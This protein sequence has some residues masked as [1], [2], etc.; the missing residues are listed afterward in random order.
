MFSDS[1]FV[2]IFISPIRIT[3]HDYFSPLDLKTLVILGE[4]YNFAVAV[5]T[6]FE[7]KK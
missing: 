6:C 5:V 3:C 7:K 2:Y 4:E 1:N